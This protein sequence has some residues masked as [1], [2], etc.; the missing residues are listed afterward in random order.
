MTENNQ[1]EDFWRYADPPEPK[2]SGTAIDRIFVLVIASVLVA[3]LGILAFTRLDTSTD[4]TV[5]ESALEAAQDT[6]QPAQIGAPSVEIGEPEIVAPP[7]AVAESVFTAATATPIPPEPTAI[8]ATTVPLPE[9]TALPVPTATPEPATESAPAEQSESSPTRTATDLV[10]LVDDQSVDT[11]GDADSSDETSGDSS[12]GDDTSGDADS[13]D[14][15][16]G[17]GASDDATSGGD[18]SDA[19]TSGDGDA[20]DNQN[21]AGA[22]GASTDTGDSGANPESTGTDDGATN[23]DG[24]SQASTAPITET[25]DAL[26]PAFVPSSDQIAMVETEMI[27]WVN[28]VRAAVGVA[29]MVFHDGLA[30]RSRQWSKVMGE[31]YGTIVHCDEV[32]R[33]A[34]APMPASCE[35]WSENIAQGFDLELIRVALLDS[36][37]HLAHM[38]DGDYTHV[39]IG[40]AYVDS[41]WW[42]T[43]SFASC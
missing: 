40:V 3:T 11:S 15:T 27:N 35:P 1:S 23:T 2:E 16:S 28:E 32:S 19:A 42:V 43:Q 29:P 33:C 21:L 17:D 6:L 14:D 36:P 34:D 5:G 20:S 9:P 38:Q 7:T 30:T 37:Q 41:S 13:D 4:V 22:D 39:G 31:Q 24:D 25:A 8:P 26:A 10:D 12:S 18:T